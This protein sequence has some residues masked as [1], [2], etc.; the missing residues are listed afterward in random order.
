MT[1]TLVHLE[2]IDGSGKSTLANAIYEAMIKL[3]IPAL[4]TR[5]PG[6]THNDA[7]NKIRDILKSE[8][9]APMSELLLFFADRAQHMDK[10][11]LPS[12]AAGMT[13]IQD[14]G[15]LSTV[16]YQ[17]H[18]RGLPLDLISALNKIVL[19]TRRPDIVL[20]IDVPVEVA[21]TRLHDRAR[22][23]LAS[24]HGAVAEITA[25]DSVAFQ[26]RVMAG[27]QNAFEYSDTKIVRLNG[28]ADISR[29]VREAVDIIL[30]VKT[31]K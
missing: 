11:V 7:T 30:S 10:V 8:T 22:T 3:D 1:G 13:V 15:P 2:G 31:G 27:Y 18:G 5:E 4:L 21:Q 16:A 28:E 17:G 9:L 19:N 23:S 14:R 12:L 6:S 20:W 29:L 26:N 25:F 24:K